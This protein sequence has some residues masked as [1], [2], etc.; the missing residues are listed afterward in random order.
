MTFLNGVYSLAAKVEG[1]MELWING[2]VFDASAKRVPKVSDVAFGDAQA[3]LERSVYLNS[4]PD[5]IAAGVSDDAMPHLAQIPVE[6]DRLL[7][8][9]QFVGYFPGCSQTTSIAQQ[10]GGDH[11]GLVRAKTPR[12]F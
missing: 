4:P 3:L 2:A 12:R 1:F 7:Q 9:C 8:F 5:L 10:L 6:V 11:A